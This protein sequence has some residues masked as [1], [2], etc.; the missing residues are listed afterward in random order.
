MA[1]EQVAE[2][3]VDTGMLS[4]FLERIVDWFVSDVFVTHTLIE[5][6]IVVAASLVAWP[7]ARL[8]RRYFEERARQQRRYAVVS[9]LWKT[10]SDVMFPFIWL[11]VQLVAIAITTQLEV[12]NAV[13]TVT[14]SLLTA[15][16]VVRLFTAFVANPFLSSAV[17]T[18]AWV[19]AALNILGILD[20]TQAILESASITLGQLKVSALTILQGLIAL[21]AL[22]WLTNVIGQVIEGRLKSSPNLTP[23]IQVLSV[24]ILRILLG[25][26]ALLA[27]LTIVGVDLTAL[28]VFGG[29]IGV[30]LGFGLQKIF[31]N[32]V[33]GFIL[34]LDK[35]IKPGDT[36]AVPGYYGRV[37]ALGA[38]YVSV[39]TRDGIEHLI[40]NEELIT[41]RVENWTHSHDLL[42]LRKQIGVHY[43]ADIPKARNLCLEALAETER[44]LD[45]PKPVCLISDFGDSAVI[46]ELRFWINDPMNG[47]ANVTSDVLGKVWDKFHEHGVEIPYPQRDLHLR[48]TSV[49]LY[50]EVAER[51]DSVHT[52][53]M[54]PS[55][56]RSE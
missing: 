17:A 48:S 28:A 49:P 22:L 5:L 24:K 53:T 44:V 29:A 9:R 54:H 11:V 8:S 45:E 15:W 37:D 20:E 36:I 30:G 19:I 52:R 43:K 47:R 34:L 18:I 16:V 33:S 26:F 40:P 1:N 56:D 4:A 51:G 39:I 2:G 27:T 42:R 3:G 14:T 55:V 6:A 46:L 35:S 21:G 38:R 50:Q 41:T 7:L 23:S 12:R 32:L 13:L 25:T 10:A 31:A